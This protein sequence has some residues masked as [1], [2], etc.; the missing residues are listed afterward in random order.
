MLYTMRR[1]K[2]NKVWWRFRW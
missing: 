2:K 1:Y